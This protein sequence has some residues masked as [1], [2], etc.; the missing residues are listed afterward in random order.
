MVHHIEV[1]VNSVS[2]LMAKK[3]IKLILDLSCSVA[4][5]VT[6]PFV[7]GVLA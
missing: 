3:L 7:G 1:H 4:H 2:E 5:T 6:L